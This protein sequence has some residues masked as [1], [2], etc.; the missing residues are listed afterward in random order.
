MLEDEFNRAKAK[1][2][3]Q[4]KELLSVGKGIIE[5]KKENDEKK[6]SFSRWRKNR[7]LNNNQNLFEVNCKLVEKE[8][9]KLDQV[10][11][12]SERVEPCKYGCYLVIGI[13]AA[14][15]SIL[16][17][18]HWF[19][20]IALKVDDKVLNP[21]L[22][23]WLERIEATSVSF[24]ASIFL[25]LCG[26]F[27]VYAALK[28]HVKF[29]LRFFF[30][31]FYPI[32]PKETFVSSFMANCL[33]MNIWMA[34]MTQFLI[35]SFR[36]YLVGTQASLIFNVQVRHMMFFGWLFERNFFVLWMIVWWWIALI[37]FILKPEEKIYLGE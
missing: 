18:V 35:Q 34:A 15:L 23:T 29:G 7:T 6:A 20:A 36:Y 17:L 28:G 24:F 25:I 33:I 5:D 11:A 2:A 1:L 9:N 21:L 32:V 10:A 37:Y 8:F 22:N 4:V 14:G 30:V 12:Y 3:Q 27:M 13:L 26:G 31:S 16:L 19:I